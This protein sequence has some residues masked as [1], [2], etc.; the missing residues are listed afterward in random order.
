[1]KVP[2]IVKKTATII[3]PARPSVRRVELEQVIMNT[4]PTVIERKPK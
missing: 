4:R 2:P 1:M 3:L